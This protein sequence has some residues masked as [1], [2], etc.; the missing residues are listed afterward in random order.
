MKKEGIL[1]K[2]GLWVNMLSIVFSI[3]FL[4]S[5]GGG[6]GGGG[7]GSSDKT[8]ISGTVLDASG[9]PISGAQVTISSTPV[10]VTTDKDG[11]FSAK[12]ELGEHTIVIMMGD[13]TIYDGTATCSGTTCNMGDVLIDGYCTFFDWG[14]YVG[15][16][17]FSPGAAGEWDDTIT[18]GTVLEDDEEPV[19]KYKMWYIGGETSAGEGVSVGYATSSDGIDWVTY[20][21]NPVMTHGSTWDINGIETITVIKDGATYKMWYEGEDISGDNTIGY[22]TSSDGINWESYSGNP[23]FSVAWDNAGTKEPWVIKDG[24]LYKMWYTSQ[25]ESEISSIGLATS[26][27]GIIWQRQGA[28]PVMSPSLSWESGEGFGNPR[29]IKNQSGYTMVYCAHDQSGNIRIG[30]ATSSDGIAWTKNDNPILEAGAGNDWDSLG[31]GPDAIVE[32]DS[33][34]KLWFIGADS[35]GTKKVGLAVKC[36]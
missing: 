6:G 4:I 25:S 22:A 14:K 1:I 7:T 5:C 13:T 32:D 15:N 20:S 2:R 34:F 30:H 36:K 35:L 11:Y 16:P 8:T 23:V 18:I 24:P 29:V 3:L 28:G 19:D 26:S 9:A 17:V 27:D 10:T 21:N 33:N 12:V 31:I